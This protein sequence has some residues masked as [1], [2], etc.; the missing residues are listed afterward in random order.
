MHQ[1]M[2]YVTSLKFKEKA[3]FN[4]LRTL[5]KRAAQQADVD[6]FDDIFDW[7][8]LLTNQEHKVDL[9]KMHK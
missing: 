8:T 2:N 9:H 4:H 3:D 6:I 7:T 1:Y 5:I